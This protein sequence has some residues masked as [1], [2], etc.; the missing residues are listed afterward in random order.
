MPLEFDSLIK[1][2][3]ALKRSVKATDQ[4][5]ESLSADLQ[6]TV[7][8]GVIQNFEVAYEQCWKFMQRWLRENQTPEEADH[9]RTRKELFRMA[10]RYELIPDPLPWFDFGNARNLTTHTYD[11]Q[12]AQESFDTARRFLSHAEHLLQRL[13]ETND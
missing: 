10:A 7:R 4:N 11:E 12:Q 3:D 6:E 5:L 9:P 13:Q 2:V 8:S 1:S